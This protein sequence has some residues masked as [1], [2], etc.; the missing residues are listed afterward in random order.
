MITLIICWTLRNHLKRKY[1]L[2]KSLI[3]KILPALS[4]LICVSS[5]ANAQEH[6]SLY[7]ILHNGELKGMLVVYQKVNGGHV[8]IKIESEVETRFLFMIIV[9]SVEEAIFEDG[10]LVYSYLYRKVN[11]QEKVNQKLQYS[12]GSYKMTTS[13]DATELPV[14]PI[15]YSVLSLYCKEPVNIGRVYSD[16]FRQYVE[17]KRVANN[18]Y[19]LILPNGNSNYYSYRD[20][21]CVGVEVDQLYNLE[22]R[23]K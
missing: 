12:G 9:K 7:N 10:I 16:N 23:L 18:K 14:Y 1:T 21:V 17:I 20:G 8:H 6:A 4:A 15:R 13:E 2:I 22:F 5:T 3:L 19:R 11:G